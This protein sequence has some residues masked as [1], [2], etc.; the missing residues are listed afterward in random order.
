MPSSCS[1]SKL[2]RYDHF[3]LHL[4][5]IIKALHLTLESMES[6]QFLVIIQVVESQLFFMYPKTSFI[7]LSILFHSFLEFP[8]IFKHLEQ[9]LQSGL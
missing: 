4:F 1:L 9:I 2:N 7:W 3:H 6:V 8:L 5:Q